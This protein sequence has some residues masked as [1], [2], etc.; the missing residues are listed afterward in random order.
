[1]SRLAKL[2]ENLELWRR[3]ST[4][5]LRDLPVG[6]FVDLAV[7][8]PLQ[9]YFRSRPPQITSTTLAIPPHRGAYR[10]RHGRGE[11]CGG[12]GSVLRATKGCRADSYE[13][14]SDTEHADERRLQRTAKSCGPDAP[15]LASSSRMLC[16]PNR[17]EAQRQSADDGGKTA[18]SPGRARRKPLKPLRAGMP[19]DP[20]VLVVARVRPTTTKCTRGRGCSGHP[21]FPTPSLGRKIHQRL[22]RIA[23][24]GRTRI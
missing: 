9:K 1:M 20:G 2:Q 12:R 24:R 17:A 14:G 11:G 16:R 6:L 13:S 5:Q 4:A 10:D 8:S 21:A 15:T 23:P 22:G 3:R 18:R 19:G 7:Q